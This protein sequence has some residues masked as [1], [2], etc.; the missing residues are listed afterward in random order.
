MVSYGKVKVCIIIVSSRAHLS[1][2]R[3]V[4]CHGRSAS[5]RRKRRAGLSH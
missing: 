1:R 4:A 3:S 2:G 5:M